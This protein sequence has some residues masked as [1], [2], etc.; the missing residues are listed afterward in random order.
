M[1]CGDL[2]LTPVRDSDIPALID[3]ASDGVRIPGTQPFLHAWDEQELPTM[4]R[5]I[6]QWQWTARANARRSAWTIEFAVRRAGKIQGIQS[7]TG[8]NYPVTRSITTTSWLG[9]PYQG[10]GTG[11]LMRAA[12]A[13]A[14]FDEFDAAELLSCVIGENP[15]SAGVSSSLGY[16]FNGTRRIRTADG[17]AAVET[18]MRLTAEALIRPAPPVVVDGASEFRAWLGLSS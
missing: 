12:I 15:A 8:E 11:T 2:E 1:R 13:A 4:A 10:R 16:T 7:V 5:G 14:F 3:A 18:S 6:A 9:R 17:S